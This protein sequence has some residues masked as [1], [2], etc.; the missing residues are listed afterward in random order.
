MVAF[1]IVLAV[2]VAGE[3]VAPEPVLALLL[4]EDAECLAHSL[5]PGRIEN[6]CVARLLPVAVCKAYR[7]AVGVDFPFPLVVVRVHFGVVALPFAAC[8]THIERVRIRVY[9]YAFELTAYRTL[10]HAA[11]LCILIGKAKVGP[12]LGSAVAKP[13][14]VNVAG[15]NEGVRVALAVILAEMYRGVQRVG[16]AVGEHPGKAR[17]GELGADFGYGGFYA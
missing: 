11:H 4:A 3:I 13:H 5:E 2:A 10:E 8:R 1:H 6:G 15:V 16:K 9:A 17:V 12:Y 7:V 14:R